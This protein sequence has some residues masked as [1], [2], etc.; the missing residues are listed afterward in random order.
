ME[1]ADGIY[2]PPPNDAPPPYDAPPPNN[3][4][5]PPYDTLPPYPQSNY[6]LNEE[7]LP[8]DDEGGGDGHPHQHSHA[9]DE[10]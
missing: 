2:R 9:Q 5:P 7:G 10:L 3:N 6:P 1:E 8:H 4:A